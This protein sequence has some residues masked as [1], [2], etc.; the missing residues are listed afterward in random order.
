MVNILACEV[1]SS[2]V[3]CQPNSG[4]TP[5][6][7][8]TPDDDHSQPDTR[9]ST[10][11]TPLQAAIARIIDQ[12][13]GVAGGGNPDHRAHNLNAMEA[14]VRAYASRMALYSEA[15]HEYVNAVGADLIAERRGAY[16]FD[17][18]AGLPIAHDSDL[19]RRE[20]ER[21]R[22]QI[23][24]PDYTPMAGE[25]RHPATAEHGGAWPN[26]QADLM[27]GYIQPEHDYQ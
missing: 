13:A 1:K 25:L 9:R 17:N 21:L 10:P 6:S 22:K 7:S 3:R 15:P 2:Q 26:A 11:E 27:P 16:R 23:F 14:D 5:Y 20:K 18:A 8:R 4:Q 12:A 24:G 19:R